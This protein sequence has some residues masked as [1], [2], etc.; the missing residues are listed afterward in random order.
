MK[1]FD[2][3][4]YAAEKKISIQEAA[5]DLRYGWFA[6]INGSGL[7]LTA[8]HADDNIETLLMTFFRGTGLKGLKGIPVSNENLRRPLLPFYKEELVAFANEHKLEWVEDASNQSSKYTRNFFRNEISL[9][10][11]KFIPR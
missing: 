5:R 6:D 10:S 4:Q 11:K 7:L 8:H 9:L 3:E 2:T 1:K